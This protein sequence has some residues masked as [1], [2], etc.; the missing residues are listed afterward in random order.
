[1]NM[2]DERL[3]EIPKPWQSE[4]KNWRNLGL[5]FAFIFL[6]LGSLMLIFGDWNDP[7]SEFQLF[8]FTCCFTS[9]GL[10]GTII[11]FAAM[12]DNKESWKLILPY[13]HLLYELVGEKLPV[14]L[15]ENNYQY[16]KKPDNLIMDIDYNK[17]T[18]KKLARSYRIIFGAPSD[19]VIEFGL[20]RTSS[21]YGY[22]Y[23]FVLFIRNINTNNLDSATEMRNKVQNMLE[24]IEYKKFKEVLKVS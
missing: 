19:I 20:T 10:I 18:K 21:K 17:E 9:V 12:F 24:E 5:A 3:H 8:L 22:V 14:M 1:M 7:E 2:E 13:N 6:A 15:K 23:S 4:S 11:A 16:V